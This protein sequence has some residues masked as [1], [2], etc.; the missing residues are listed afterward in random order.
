MEYENK[1]LKVG[2]FVLVGLICVMIFIILLGSDHAFFNKSTRYH[3]HL[4]QAQGIS[5]GSIVSLS[6]IKVGNVRHIEYME[7][8]QKVD[9]SI[10]VRSKYTHLILTNT[11]ASIKT[12]GALGDKF[13][14]LSPG[15]SNAEPI[16]DNGVI[17]TKTEGGLFDV[18]SEKGH[19][20]EKVFDILNET[21]AF[22]KQLNEN[23]RTASMMKNIETSSLNLNKL[24]IETQKLV[25][26]V[27]GQQEQKGQLKDSIQGLASII[28]KID[29]GK[30]TLGALINDSQIHDRLVGILG[31]SPRNR[32]L[33]PLIRATIQK[34]ESKNNLSD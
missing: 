26:D 1:P 10:E 11:Q 13:I 29:Q 5:R 32:Y 17:P 12:Q 18:I 28:K 21:H 19:Q 14:L 9:V 30:G 23:N 27:R 15:E 25:N 3:I 31:D 16:P 22:F 24:L 4:Q 7:S 33:K 20:F 6:G 2:A 8:H 34:N